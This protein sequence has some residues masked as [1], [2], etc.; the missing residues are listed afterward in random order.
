MYN[1]VTGCKLDAKIFIGPVHYQALPHLVSKKEQ[2]RGTGR[3][4]NL[5]HQPTAGIRQEGGLRFG[6]MEKDI[7]IAYGSS[8]LLVERLC[9][10]SDAFKA[11]TCRKCGQFAQYSEPDRNY[12]CLICADSLNIK[13][14]RVSYPIKLFIQTLAGAH[15]NIGM[16]AG[17]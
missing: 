2:A 5:T 15:V 14:S 9:I 8:Y 11:V 4:R 13:I 10:S 16:F 7:L 12:K 1:G 6:E 3:K 17:E